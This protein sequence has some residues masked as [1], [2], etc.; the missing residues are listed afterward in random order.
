MALLA[1]FWLTLLSF[2]AL[3][4]R[5]FFLAAA[6]LCF[7]LDFCFFCCLFFVFV[8][9]GSSLIVWCSWQCVR[10]TCTTQAQC[11]S[12]CQHGW[13]CCCYG[14]W[15]LQRPFFCLHLLHSILQIT[16]LYSWL[17]CGSTPGSL[18]SSL[19]P[20]P[21]DPLPPIAY[22]GI[23]AQDASGY[24]LLQHLPSVLSFLIQHHQV[25]KENVLVHCI[26]GTSVCF[27]SFPRL[28]I[29][30]FFHSFLLFSVCCNVSA[31]RS[32]S[33]VIAFLM[34]VK[35]MTLR[36][37]TALTIRSRPS[38]FI[39]DGFIKQLI[40]LEKRLQTTKWWRA[41][42]TNRGGPPSKKDLEL[43]EEQV[44]QKGNARLWRQ[45]HAAFTFR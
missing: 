7:V 27:L 22:L 21:S 23:D 11:H 18:P 41:H 2:L 43:A 44:K 31:S 34:I 12:D 15:F 24:S 35:N 40:H 19:H 26:A 30:S 6:C 10:S 1:L 14:T 45:T 42:H 8:Y 39:N 13:R 28:V 20:L 17:T 32:P 4:R 38:I 16:S 25:L 9:F 36:Q 33:I 5:T 3:V 37:A 29:F